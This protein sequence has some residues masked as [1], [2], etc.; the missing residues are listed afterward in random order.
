MS[1]TTRQ[2]HT[3]TQQADVRD[4]MIRRRAGSQG[5][6]GSGIFRE[7]CH[8][9]RILYRLGPSTSLTSVFLCS[10]SPDLSPKCT[11]LKKQLSSNVCL[12]FSFCYHYFQNTRISQGHRFYHILAL[13]RRIC[14]TFWAAHRRGL[15][16]GQISQRGKAD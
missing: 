11:S 4:C 13:H 6:E 14:T 7:L 9:S 1:G 16:Q 3:D 2:P 5:K 12:F 8:P 10:E 15:S